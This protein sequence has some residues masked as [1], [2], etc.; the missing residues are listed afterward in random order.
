MD[1]EH[2]FT[3]LNRIGCRKISVGGQMVRATC[4]FE[5]KHGGGSDKSPS[6]A[7]RIADGDSSFNCKACDIGGSLESLV[8]RL[9]RDRRLPLKTLKGLNEFILTHD[10]VSLAELKRRAAGLEY[11]KS[12]VREIAGIR[13]STALVPQSSKSVLLE[14][15]TLP[16]DYL[17]SYFRDPEGEALEYLYG[18]GLDDSTI[19]AWELRWH[20]FQR[21]IAIPIRDRKGRLVGI[22]GRAVGANRIPKYL[23][24]KGFRRDHYL[25]GENKVEPSG[26]AYLVEGQFDVIGLWHYGYRN[27]VAVLGSHLTKFQ[28][29]KVVQF[30]SEVVIVTDGDN[31][32]REAGARFAGALRPRLRSVRVVDTPDGKDPGSLTEDEASE[33]LGPPA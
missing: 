31:A 15:P 8:V 24:S 22:S 20:R 21:R 5:Y 3:L 14:T 13:V 7:V 9:D 29:E 33:L 11:G 27:V 18:R 25:F 10:R 30:F 4:P 2:I 6:F 19:Q 28:A 1:V 23:H 32:G 12:K 16:E 26:T 17:T